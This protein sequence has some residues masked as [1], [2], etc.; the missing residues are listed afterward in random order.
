MVEIKTPTPR[1]SLSFPKKVQL[2]SF[3]QNHTFGLA[4]GALGGG[5]TNFLSLSV[6]HAMPFSVHPRVAVGG[7]NVS[8]RVW[9]CCEGGRR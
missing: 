6:F 9:V 7:K 3:I 1:T 8:K 5:F 4:A 2:M